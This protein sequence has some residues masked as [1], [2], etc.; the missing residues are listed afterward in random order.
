MIKFI[1]NDY[2]KDAEI[3]NQMLKVSIK[4]KNIKSSNELMAY[5]KQSYNG[6]WDEVWLKFRED[7]SLDRNQYND[8]WHYF[9][10]LLPNGLQ[11]IA[12]AE[13]GAKRNKKNLNFD[14]YFEK[15]SA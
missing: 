4:D 11:V 8:Y 5:V 13:I 9:S 1:G 7:L 6:F 10:E 12:N 2:M 15:Y 14:L 3:V